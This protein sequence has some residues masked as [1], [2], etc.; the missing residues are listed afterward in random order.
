V[1]VGRAGCCPV[2]EIF[3]GVVM[4]KKDWYECVII[5]QFTLILILETSLFLSVEPVGG[6]I[7]LVGTSLLVLLWAII[8]VMTVER[9]VE[10]YQ[11]YRVETL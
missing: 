4:I 8:T 11:E 2:S 1:Y 10:F 5:A 3:R 9:G 7:I 6:V